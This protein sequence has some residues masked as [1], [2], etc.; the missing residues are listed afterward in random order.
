[1]QLGAIKSKISCL[2]GNI[3]DSTFF[4]QVGRYRV[5]I[6]DWTAAMAK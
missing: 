5:E 4:E 1:M 3:L 2:I 6:E